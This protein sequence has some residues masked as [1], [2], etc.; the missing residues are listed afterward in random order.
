MKGLIHIVELIVVALIIV[1][2]V[3]LYP[4]F[5]NMK[6]DYGTAQAIRDIE[7]HLRENQGRWPKSPKQLG[8][9]YPLGDEVVVDYSATSSELVADPDGL[10]NAVRPRSG[11]FYTYP[12]YD[13]QIADLLLALRETNDSELQPATAVDSKASGNEKLNQESEGRS[14]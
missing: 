11:K 12:H 5:K 13:M 10:R 4:N 8:R 1:V 6:S 3:C 14:Q 7:T 2:A 9:K